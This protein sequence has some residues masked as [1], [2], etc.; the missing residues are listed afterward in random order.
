MPHIK[1]NDALKPPAWRHLGSVVIITVAVALAGC[2]ASPTP[3]DAPAIEPAEAVTSPSP[4]PV[5]RPAVPAPPEQLTFEAGA[6]LDSEVWLAGWHVEPIDMTHGYS[7][8]YPRDDWEEKHLSNGCEGSR[9]HRFGPLDGLDL[10]LDDRTLTDQFL[11]QLLEMP[12]EDVS[13]GGSDVSFPV[14]GRWPMMADFR[15]RAGDWTDGGT[16]LA[17]ARVFGALDTALVIQLDCDPGPMTGASGQQMFELLPEVVGLDAFEV[18]LGRVDWNV[19]ESLDFDE[20]ADLVAS[21]EARWVDS[22][23][24]EDPA[25]TFADVEAGV[26]TFTTADGDCTAEYEQGLLD[27]QTAAPSDREASDKLLAASL[28]VPDSMVPQDAVDGAFAVAMPGNDLVAMRLIERENSEVRWVT[29]ARAFTGPLLGM[30]IDVTCSEGDPMK[31]LDLLMAKSA[32]QV[33]P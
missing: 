8:V 32:V 20:G 12:I 6:G 13:E 5:S 29:A 23:L 27:E 9:Y 10:T 22:A 21:S 31:T 1:R 16:W 7:V 17:A 15:V 25:W 18:G 14:V 2:T 11:A 26:W 33:V 4:S 3:E 30:T 24:M 28:G 19:V